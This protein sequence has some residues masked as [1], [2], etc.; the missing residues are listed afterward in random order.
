M[1]AFDSLTRQR[2]QIGGGNLSRG[3]GSL[4]LQA[5]QEED[6]RGSLEDAETAEVA[7]LQNRKIMRQE[8]AKQKDRAAEGARDNETKMLQSPFGAAFDTNWGEFYGNNETLRLAEGLTKGGVPAPGGAHLMGSGGTIG[9][10]GDAERA[11]D[12][13][14]SAA[15]LA[16]QKQGSG[17]GGGG[18]SSRPMEGGEVTYSPG[19]NYSR[20]PAMGEM[21]VERLKQAKAL[22]ANMEAQ[23]PNATD[24][25]DRLNTLYAHGSGEAKYLAQQKAELDTIPKVEAA[26]AQFQPDIYRAQ[27]SKDRRA[28]E[29][30]APGQELAL[31]K[32]QYGL[33]GD[34]ARANAT[35][36]SAKV[37]AQSANLI[38]MVSNMRQNAAANAQARGFGAGDAEVKRLDEVLQYL[39]QL[40][41]TPA[42]NLPGLVPPNQPAVGGYINK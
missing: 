25:R 36:E 33:A 16:L 4:S 37:K 27:E 38:A 24:E 42:I 11:N 39:Y 30:A 34:E 40:A 41:G 22:T 2:R 12:A 5:L 28:T 13:R 23:N 21:D 8:L 26:K 6:A 31:A 15:L 10:A 14:Q 1:T 29:M 7:R 9:S 3:I 35:I 19:G 32:A 17:G 20:G 18:A